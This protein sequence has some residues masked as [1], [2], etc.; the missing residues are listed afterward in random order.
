MAS[1]PV[2]VSS[3]PNREFFTLRNWERHK[4]HFVLFEFDNKSIS[5]LETNLK[6]VTYFKITLSPI[7]Q[8]SRRN[9]H[10]PVLCRF[11][12]FLINGPRMN[13]DHRFWTKT[14]RASTQDQFKFAH[15]TFICG[16]PSC[17]RL[18][19]LN[20][21][22]RGEE[23]NILWIGKR[24]NNKMSNTDSYYETYISGLRTVIYVSPRVLYRE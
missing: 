12:F 8:S 10:M 22:V 23:P 17:R 9:T 16:M 14:F 20:V 5:N 7:F 6:V 19:H 11:L 21:N 15:W 18:S 24:L 13:S 1:V 4:C 2:K 3:F